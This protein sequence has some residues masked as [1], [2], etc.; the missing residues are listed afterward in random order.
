MDKTQVWI[1]GRLTSGQGG[2]EAPWDLQGVF[3]IE[4]LADDACRDGSYFIFPVN[5]DEQLPHESVCPPG[6]RYPRLLPR[7]EYV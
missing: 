5:M 4:K 7:K 6:G 3:S 1:C 2:R